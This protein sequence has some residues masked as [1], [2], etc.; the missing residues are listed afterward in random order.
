MPS[1]T[2]DEWNDSII[3]REGQ[4]QIQLPENLTPPEEAPA[5]S[6]IETAKAAFSQD[7]VIANVYGAIT[8][9]K[10]KTNP[11]YNA[12]DRLDKLGRPDLYAQ[13]VYADSDEELFSM[14]DVVD[15]ERKDKQTLEDSGWMGTT[16]SLGAMIMDPTIFVPGT[17][18][19]KLGRKL[20]Q[21]GRGMAEGA[22]L[23]AGVVTAQESI[24]QGSQLDRPKSLLAT[25]AIAGLAL[26]GIVGGGMAYMSKDV[27]AGQQ[28]V[29]GEILSGREPSMVISK[30]GAEVSLA[31]FMFDAPE[32]MEGLG[33]TGPAGSAGAMEANLS[34]NTAEFGQ[35]TAQEE[36]IWRLNKT[37]TKALSSPVRSFRSPIVNANSSLSG[38]MKKGANSLLMHNYRSAKNAGPEHVP[39]GPSV[40]ALGELDDAVALQL[41]DQIHKIYQESIGLKGA[42][43]AQTRSAVG[44]VL[45]KHRTWPEFDVEVAKAI[46]NRGTTT[47][48]DVLKAANLLGSEISTVTKKLQEIGI[49][50]E[51]LKVTTADSY[52]SRKYNVPF[53]TSSTGGKDFKALLT[54]NFARDSGLA[55]T[56]KKIVDDVVDTINNIK[57]LGDDGLQVSSLMKPPSTGTNF[58]KARVLDISDADLEPFLINSGTALTQDYVK[59]AN[60]LIRLQEVMEREGFKDVAGWKTDIRAEY[61]AITENKDVVVRGNLL[62]KKFG[63]GAEVEKLTNEKLDKMMRQDLKDADTMVASVTGQLGRNS[64]Y[65]RLDK[66][67]GHVRKFNVLTQLGGVAISSMSDMAMPIF[68]HGPMRYLQDG[69][70]PMLRSIKASKAAK[71]ELFDFAVGNE[72]IMN[73]ITRMMTDASFSGLKNDDPLSKFMSFSMD[74][75]GKVSLMTYWN[76]FHKRMAGQMSAART[77]RALKKYSKGKGIN[78]EEATRLAMLGIGED[79]YAALWGQFEKYGVET[80]GSFIADYADWDNNLR[81]LMGTGILNEVNAT[82]ITPGRSDIPFIVQKSGL[83]QTAFQYKPFIAAATNKILLSGLQRRDKNAL[84]GVVT[85]VIYGG[86]S[87]ATKEAI[88][89]K[90][91]TEDFDNSAD[92]LKRFVTEGISRSGIGGQMAD[93]F[94]AL[95]PFGIEA[96]YRGANAMSYGLGPVLETGKHVA[97]VLGEI[98]TAPFDDKETTEAEMKARKRLVPGQNLFWLNAAQTVVE[99][100]SLFN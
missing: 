78:D 3:P 70:S 100:G 11:N 25:S 15:K 40:E 16:L 46:R 22:A 33:A 83:M 61:L 57:G 38:S 32:L 9:D 41:N 34:R 96:R 88:K 35:M 63:V 29:M 95:N 94:F 19:L 49:F 92:L 55:P 93:M 44:G 50:S 4:G 12:M 85:V 6:F 89:G 45:G 48:P 51:E 23:G 73:E 98:A 2:N 56:N 36:G 81:E 47:D 21:V 68:V 65:P 14:I 30:D 87:W 8:S 76:R 53:I 31:D 72:L 27:A 80:K 77:F 37:L 52:L 20:F 24:L 26:G 62:K 43:G 79:S 7:N 75:F 13:G 18:Q 67:L 60:S 28:Y 59:Q 97:S 54:R 5:P 64:G 1:I 58:T 71:D 74:M 39:T 99:N 69:I 17:M 91:V 86:L 66:A 90:D 82:I 42:V 10:E 84:M